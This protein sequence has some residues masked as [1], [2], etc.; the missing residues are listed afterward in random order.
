MAKI[1][2]DGA[3]ITQTSSSGHITYRSYDYIRESA[4]YC[5]R[6]DEDGDCTSTT[7]DPIYEW[8]NHTTSANINGTVT[9]TVT[10]VKI[11]GKAPIVLGD[12]TKE[13]DTYSLPS[14]GVYVS[15]QH[16]NAA[17]TVTVGNAKN[18]FINGK[19]VAIANAAVTTHAGTSSTIKDG[20]STTVNIGG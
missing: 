20:L 12:K 6:W 19:L 18:V 15:G 8:V 9:P 2:L 3:T 13:T 16:T 5:T 7:T 10:N 11:N 4:P 1:A 17:G 14:G